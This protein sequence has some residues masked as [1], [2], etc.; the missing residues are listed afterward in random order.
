[1][2]TCSQFQ[3]EKCSSEYA[4]CLL[5]SSFS[6]KLWVTSLKSSKNTIELWSQK[7]KD[8]SS[9]TG[10]H[11]LLDLRTNHCRRTWS[12]RLT[13]TFHSIGQMIDLN[14]S[15]RMMNTLTNAPE[16]LKNISFWSTYL[17]MSFTNSGPFLILLITLIRS[18]CMIFALDLSQL[19]LST[20]MT[21]M[22]RWYL[23]RKMKLHTCTSSKKEKLV[24]DIT[25]WPK[26][27]AK[28]SS[29]SPSNYSNF[30]TYVT[31]MCALTKNVNSFTWRVKT[32]WPCS[33]KSNSSFET[34]SQS[35]LKSQSKSRRNLNED[36]S[37]MF[38]K[39]FSTSGKNTFWML[40]IKTPTNKS[41]SW[42]SQIVR[43]NMS[44]SE[45][46]LLQNW[47]KRV[48]WKRPKEASMD[49][50][51]WRMEIMV[52]SHL[53]QRQSIRTCLLKVAQMKW[54]TPVSI[55]K[56]TFCPRLQ[57]LILFKIKVPKMKCQSTKP[58]LTSF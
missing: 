38:V 41:T 39:S 37:T 32:L 8:L 14:R 55:S 5:E 17:T 35:I 6:P 30:P 46:K 42:T 1:M 12:T 24:S 13:S 23:M 36:I 43:L 57:V 49:R 20:M 15:R 50:R 16:V 29:K 45:T 18:S 27:W 2:V 25:L 54:R 56:A 52:V 11:C 22:I 9:I 40:I 28:T 47:K 19:S 51:H 31:T 33:L 34:S 58:T 53:N 4:L 3:W 7:N 10:W 48:S 26:A 44:L 21:S